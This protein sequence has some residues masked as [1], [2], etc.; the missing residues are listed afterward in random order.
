MAIVT[1]CRDR[2]VGPFTI[3][4][5]A[6]TQPVVMTVDGGAVTVLDTVDQAWRDLPPTIDEHAVGGGQPQQRRLAGT[7]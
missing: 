3:N 1:K 7:E 6:V 5:A 4:A 2:L